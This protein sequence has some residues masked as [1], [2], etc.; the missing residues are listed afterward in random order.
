[1]VLLKRE[2]FVL[3]P[4]QKLLEEEIRPRGQ[5][6]PEPPQVS[7]GHIWRSDDGERSTP[8]WSNV[9]VWTLE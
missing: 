3:R 9:F 2:T 7:A 8:R 1:M 6:E 4:D 5:V